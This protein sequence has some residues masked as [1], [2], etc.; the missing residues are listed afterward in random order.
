MRMRR[1]EAP[2]S[3]G[4]GRL[5]TATTKKPRAA[6]DVVNEGIAP[7]ECELSYRLS[8]RH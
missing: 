4:R 1:K 8:C 2:L 7:P 6:G 3:R 5:G